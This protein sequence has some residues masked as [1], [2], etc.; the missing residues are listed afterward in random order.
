MKYRILNIL[1]FLPWPLTT[2]GHNGC[3]HSIE[4]MKNLVD[5]YVLFPFANNQKDIEYMKKLWPEVTWL[6]YKRKCKFSRKTVARARSLYDRVQKLFYNG[7]NQNLEWN[8]P[9]DSERYEDEYLDSINYYIKIY[10]IDIVQVEFPFM[11]SL[12]ACLPDNVK[13]VFVH[14]ELRFV[15][16]ELT[17]Q[18][19]NITNAYYK[20]YASKTKIE[21]IAYLNQYDHVVTFSP[22]DRDKLI[23]AGLIVPCSASFLIVESRQKGNYIPATDKLTFL[24][25]GAHLPNS[26]GLKWFLDKEWSRMLVKHPNLTLL[27]IGKWQEEVKKEFSKKYSN[28]VFKGFVEDLQKELKGSIMIVPL[29]IGS[30]IRIKIL[31]CASIGVP[32]VSTNVGA[33]GLPFKNNENC[34]LV[35]N[36]DIFAQKISELLND[37]VLQEKFAVSSYN[38][39]NEHFSMEN[40]QK[41][42]MEIYKSLGIK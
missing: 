8:F 14:H 33:E 37:P 16:N 31:E 39:I 2:G 35:D 25:A 29:T 6:P 24:G 18:S 21:E 10:N 22:V 36:P 26:L 30:G 3:Y 19:G 34:F 1:P 42:R 27:I 41:S 12:V 17:L 38:I 7:Y 23:E 40:F 28:I 20:F 11:L 9:L 5:L 13:K 32:F 15:R 4:A